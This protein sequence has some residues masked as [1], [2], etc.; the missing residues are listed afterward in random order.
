MKNLSKINAYI[1][2]SKV[3]LSCNTHEQLTSTSNMAMNFMYRYNDLSLYLSLNKNMS[4]KSK[5]LYVN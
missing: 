5:Y 1:K 4:V 2:I 3:I